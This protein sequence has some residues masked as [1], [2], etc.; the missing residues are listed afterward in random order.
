[1]ASGTPTLMY[2]LGCLP[3]DYY[4]YLYFMEDESVDGI[5]NK[6]IDICEKSDDELKSFGQKASNFIINEKNEKK[7]AGKI[8]K[9]ITD[10]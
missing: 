3:K 6:L 2:R 8:S 10:L 5:K 1:M 4:P 7:Q 9:F